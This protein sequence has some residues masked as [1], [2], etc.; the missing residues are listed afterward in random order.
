MEM[1]ADASPEAKVIWDLFQAFLIEARNRLNQMDPYIP[2][3]HLS[4]EIRLMIGYFLGSSTAKMVVASKRSRNDW[5]AY[6]KENFKRVQL[7]LGIIDFMITSYDFA[8]GTGV[9]RALVMKTLSQNYRDDIAGRVFSQESSTLSTAS[10]TTG[11]EEVTGSQ[12]GDKLIRL[13]LEIWNIER[14]KRW[15]HIKSLVKSQ[16]FDSKG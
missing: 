10:D 15:N 7:S 11:C 1:M 4:N 13:P 5:N 6:Q 2:Q 14:R 3:N 16:D 8:G 12:L 9:D